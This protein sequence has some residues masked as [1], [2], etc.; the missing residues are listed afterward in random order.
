MLEPPGRVL[1]VNDLNVW[2]AARPR[3]VPLGVLV[4]VRAMFRAAV[5]GEMSLAICVLCRNRCSPLLLVLAA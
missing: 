1:Q 3:L 4:R 2:V 5:G